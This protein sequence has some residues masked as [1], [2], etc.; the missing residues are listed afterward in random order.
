MIIL[1]AFGR[2][3]SVQP[4]EEPLEGGGSDWPE[5]GLDP[6]HLFRAPS[7]RSSAPAEF[8][9]FHWLSLHTTNA[10][11]CQEHILTAPLLGARTSCSYPDTPL[12][13]RRR[14]NRWHLPLRTLTSEALRPSPTGRG[15]L[16]RDPIAALLVLP[17]YC[18][19]EDKPLHCSSPD[20][21]AVASVAFPE[22]LRS[23]P[24]CRVRA[25]GSIR[26]PFTPPPVLRS[27]D[28]HLRRAAGRLAG[29]PSPERP[30]L[31]SDL[32]HTALACCV[33]WS[34]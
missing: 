28:T 19:Q 4:H 8:G 31:R 13:H 1:A 16:A 5:V 3:S 34:A 30:A 14:P 18:S 32:L 17:W 9:R 20:T 6:D 7:S 25:C 11:S 22:Q 27:R 29:R 23:F 26:A 12:E 33:S 15:H 21:T 10:C 2:E 24:V